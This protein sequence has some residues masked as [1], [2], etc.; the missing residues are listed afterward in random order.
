MLKHLSICAALLAFGTGSVGAQQEEKIEQ[1]EK[2]KVTMSKMEV[3]GADYDIIFITT[4]SR[5]GMT[6]EPDPLAY[7][8]LQTRVY[9]VPKGK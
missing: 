2:H 8:G 3:P 6:D 4:E 5:A 1:K 7:A 9:L